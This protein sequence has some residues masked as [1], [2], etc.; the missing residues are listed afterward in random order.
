MV[1]V[2]APMQVEE[3]QKITRSLGTLIAKSR[4]DGFYAKGVIATVPL[5]IIATV[6]PGSI[7]REDGRITFAYCSFVA[8]FSGSHWDTASVGDMYTDSGILK[9]INHYLAQLGFK[10]KVH[11]SE[12]GRQTDDE[13]DFDMD[14]GLID[15]LWPDLVQRAE[16]EIT[17]ELPA[18][19]S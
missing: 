14:F 3:N 2:G 17:Q 8:R 1:G 18:M 5:E 7:E 10:S 4:G 9:S 16:A 11:W 12:H 6:D 13:A 19:R 15:E